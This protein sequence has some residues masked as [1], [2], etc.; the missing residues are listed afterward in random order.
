MHSF[1]PKILS[2]SQHFLPKRGSKVTPPRLDLA[3]ISLK[4]YFQSDPQLHILLRQY[5]P[6]IIFQ[7]DHTVGQK[8]PPLT[9]RQPSNV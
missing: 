6:A 3:V 5:S 2:P 9:S 4:N 7:L 1:G 8:S